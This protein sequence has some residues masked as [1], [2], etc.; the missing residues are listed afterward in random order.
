MNV[1][2]LIMSKSTP[3]VIG[4]MTP[5]KGRMEL[6]PVSETLDPCHDFLRLGVYSSA[7]ANQCVEIS[8]VPPA[9]LL[10]SQEPS[11]VNDEGQGQILMVLR[12]QLNTRVGLERK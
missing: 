9:S 4:I 8:P 5:L 6:I 3:S 11:S 2:V 7:H 10:G 1:D 12:S